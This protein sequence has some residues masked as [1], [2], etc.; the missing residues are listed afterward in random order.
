MHYGTDIIMHTHIYICVCTSSVANNQ[1]IHVLIIKLK[2]IK[3]ASVRN[4]RT[5]SKSYIM[6]VALRERGIGWV[7]RCIKLDQVLTHHTQSRDRKTT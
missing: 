5:T 3:I 2:S 7:I 6:Q 1:S 4:H